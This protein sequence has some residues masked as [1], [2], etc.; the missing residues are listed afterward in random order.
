MRKRIDRPEDIKGILDKLIGKIEKRSPGKRE[1]ILNAWQGAVGERASCHSRPVSISRKTLI[2][3]IDSS[4][5]FYTL[6]LKKKGILK[7]IKKKL[8]EDKVKDIR[9]RMGDIT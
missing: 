9:F 7:D 5:W 2:V 3:E 6:N 8:G 1:K 4:T